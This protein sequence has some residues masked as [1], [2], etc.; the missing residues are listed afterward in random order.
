MLAKALE[1]VGVL[2]VMFGGMCLD[3]PCM[4]IPAG[5]VLVG[6]VLLTYGA[7]EDGLFRKKNR[8]R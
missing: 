5:I 3:G 2:L 6:L 8:P 7:Y 1:A 4:A